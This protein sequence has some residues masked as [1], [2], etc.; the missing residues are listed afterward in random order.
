MECSLIKMY[1][2]GD[3]EEGELLK[4]IH[5]E[6]DFDLTEFKEINVKQRPGQNIQPDNNKESFYNVEDGKIKTKKNT[7]AR[8]DRKYTKKSF[9][10]PVCGRD[11]KDEPKKY[12][13]MRSRKN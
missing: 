3:I 9:L 13:H 11:F 6:E 5:F 12:E 4:P 2:S 7:N 8:K 10:C 1:E